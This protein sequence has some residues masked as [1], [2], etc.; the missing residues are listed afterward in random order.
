MSYVGVFGLITI[1]G[2]LI[3]YFAQAFMTSLGQNPQQS[4]Q[5]L[6]I[7]L[8]EILRAKYSQK[9]QVRFIY[10]SLPFR[11]LISASSSRAPIPWCVLLL[12][13]FSAF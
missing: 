5:Q 4:Y 7:S 6:L 10:P 2:V 13:I 1:F 9:P 11:R 3:G 8:R 12:C